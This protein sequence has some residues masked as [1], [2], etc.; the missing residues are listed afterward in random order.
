MP[1]AY[2]VRFHLH[3]AV[4]ASLQGDGESVMMRLHGGG[5]WRLRAEGA[6]VTLEESVYLGAHEPRRAEQ[7]VLSGS[8]EGAQHVKWAITKVG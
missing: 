6:R 8:A 1:Q 2:A 7:I 4:K 3:P 5:S